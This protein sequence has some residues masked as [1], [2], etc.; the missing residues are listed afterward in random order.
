MMRAADS[1][2]QDLRDVE[3]IQLRAKSGLVLVLWHT[4]GGDELVDAAV[5]DAGDGIAAEDAVSDERDDGCGT[6]LLQEL[7]RAC[8]LWSTLVERRCMNHSKGAHGVAGVNEIVDD[9]ADTVCY[10]ADEDH[11]G[12]LTV[13]DLGRTALLHMVRS[14]P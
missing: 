4:V 2:G 13:G 5:L 11:A 14:S 7:G 6:L 1:L 9:D 3:N 8:N 12:A 10:I